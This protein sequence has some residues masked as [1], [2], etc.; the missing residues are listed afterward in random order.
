[1]EQVVLGEAL[2]LCLLLEAIETQAIF[3]GGARRHP[4]QHGHH[5]LIVRRE[6]VG[7]AVQIEPHGAQGLPVIRQINEPHVVLRLQPLEGVD[8]LP[9]HLVGVANGVVI[10]IDQLLVGAIFD[11]AARAIWHEGALRGRVAPVIGGAM[12]AHQVEGHQLVA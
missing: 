10:G 3:L 9:Y 2:G 11:V 8:Q 4:G 6:L 1:M 12:A 5:R 7:G